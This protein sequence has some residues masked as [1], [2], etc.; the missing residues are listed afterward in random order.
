M[1]NLPR[2]KVLRLLPLLLVIAVARAT[3]VVPP[4]FDELLADSSLVFRGEV[5]AVRV[6]VSGDAG[7]RHPA[8]FVTFA[9]ERVL[10]GAAEAKITL[11]FMGGEISGRRV[12]IAGLP[13]FVPRERGVFFVENRDGR[14]CPITRLRHG[15]YRIVIEPA[16]GIE[17]V[18]RDD[19][20]ALGALADVHAALSDREP[21]GAPAVSTAGM[22]LGAFE[23]A[24]V[25]RA[26]LSQTNTPR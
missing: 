12:E 22:E 26:Q 5:T 10:K 7:T 24:I 14:L 21:R 11:E 23:Q 19:G 17:R 25:T 8:T 16:T 18:T 6:A 15:R 2:V 13:H 4:S 20:S 3:S 1:G 9:V